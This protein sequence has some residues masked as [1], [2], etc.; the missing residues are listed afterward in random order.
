MTEKKTYN[1]G[2]K[3]YFTDFEEQCLRNISEMNARSLS[4]T[5]RLLLLKE[6]KRL[7][8]EGA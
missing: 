3:I 1:K 4:Q 7:E 6:V 5:M 8:D 2:I